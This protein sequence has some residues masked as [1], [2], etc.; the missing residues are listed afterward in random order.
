VEAGPNPAPIIQSVDLVKKFQ[1]DSAA[2]SAKYGFKILY[3]IGEIVEM[4]ANDPA[5]L[6]LK[7]EGA[8]A[9]RIQTKMLT[10]VSKLKIGEQAQFQGRFESAGD[11]GIHPSLTQ[12][13]P[14]FTPLPAPGISYAE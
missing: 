8:G 7:G 6:V 13:L 12:C 11:D 3:V 14:V 4:D 1:S 5:N 10:D 2:A 9:V